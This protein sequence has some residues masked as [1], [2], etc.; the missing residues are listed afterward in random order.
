VG[1]LMKLAGARFLYAGAR[2]TVL[3]NMVINLMIEFQITNLEW[4]ALILIIQLEL[5]L[6]VM[7]SFLDYQS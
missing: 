7:T 6:Q 5:F 3:G 4:R 1:G 2:I